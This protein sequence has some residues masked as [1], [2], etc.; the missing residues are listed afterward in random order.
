VFLAVFFIKTPVRV[1]AEPVPEGCPGTSNPIQPPPPICGTIPIGCQGSSQQGPVAEIPDP[2]DCPYSVEGLIDTDCDKEV[3]T[4]GNC[5][6]IKILVNGINFLS[7]LA[8]MAIIASIIVAGYQ[9]MTA[10]DNSGQI[11]AARTRIIWAIVAL[12]MF[13]FM[14]AFLNWVVPGG[15]I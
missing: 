10:Q 2:A 12:V 8:G 6:I 1:S 9:Y 15:V 14:Y 5:G 3:L 4:S 13:I 11:Q 7:A